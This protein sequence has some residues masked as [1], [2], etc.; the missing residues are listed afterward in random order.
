MNPCEANLCQG[1]AIERDC[2]LMSNMAAQYHGLNAGTWKTLETECVKLAL[3]YDSI[4]VFCGS[5]GEFKK[6][7]RVSVPTQCWK[8]V[9]IRKLNLVHCYIFENSG[10]NIINIRKEIG[11]FDLEKLTGLKFSF[12]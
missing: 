10:N 4:H 7:G 5:I 11:I 8:V 6:I 9:Y 3:Q 12:K 1:D 2:F